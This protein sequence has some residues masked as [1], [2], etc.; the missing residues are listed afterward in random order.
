M[1]S[2]TTRRVK[3]K[4]ACYALGI[5]HDTFSRRWQNVF[6]ETRE[7]GN[8]RRGVPRLVLEDELS[9]AVEFGAAAVATFRR[10]MKRR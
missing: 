4:D 5:S 2:L 6:T 10:T 3:L 8:R 9:V 7:P 1:P